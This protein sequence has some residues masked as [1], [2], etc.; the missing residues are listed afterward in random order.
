MP[1]QKTLTNPTPNRVL[2]SQTE[3][4]PAPTPIHETGINLSQSSGACCPERSSEEL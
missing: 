4:S 3:D 2:D 1:A